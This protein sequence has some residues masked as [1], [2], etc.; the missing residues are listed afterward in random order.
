MRTYNLIRNSPQSEDCSKCACYC[1]L[2]LSTA[3]HV[4]QRALLGDC[5]EAAAGAGFLEALLASAA[6]A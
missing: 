5:A 4:V 3:G 6:G 2:R 1:L